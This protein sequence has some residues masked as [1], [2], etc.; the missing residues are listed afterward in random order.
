MG[1]LK[2]RKGEVV[3]KINDSVKER[4]GDQRIS[5]VT[6]SRAPSS[7]YAV[8]EAS[9]RFVRVVLCVRIV[10]VDQGVFVSVRN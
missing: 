7:Q 2:E 5:V 4:E 3:S 10:V 6:I 9:A 8:H 1:D